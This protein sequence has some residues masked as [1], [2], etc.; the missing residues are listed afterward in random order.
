MDHTKAVATGLQYRIFPYLLAHVELDRSWKAPQYD[1]FYSQSNEEPFPK[2]WV[3]TELGAGFRFAWRE[4]IIQT[5]RSRFSLGSDFPILSFRF[6]QG[7]N[8]FLD[9][10]F[11]YR[12]FDLKI[13]HSIYTKYLGETSLLIR[14][15]LIDSDLPYMQ[16]YSGFGSYG[17]FAIHAPESFSTMRMNEFTADQYVSLYLTHNF[18][19]LLYRTKRFEPE[20]VIATHTG[21]GW[22][23]NQIPEHH[24]IALQ[25][26]EKGYFESG[27]LINNL[28]NLQFFN[29]GF[30]AFYRYGP[31][32]RDGFKQNI[33]WRLSMSFLF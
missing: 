28:L 22:L 23:R 25:S 16:L 27:L 24:S 3:F 32:A 33:S 29:L 1:Y 26:F 11:S 10:E 14:A 30:G 31:Y 21:F 13:E 7:L 12:R 5:T 2:A 19:K 6:T 17:R 20:F 18:G 8:G 15:G 9:G 4:K